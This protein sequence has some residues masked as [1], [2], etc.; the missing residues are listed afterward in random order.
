MTGVQTCA[1]PICTDNIVASGGNDRIVG[2]AGDDFL[3]GG[4]G[5]DIF[6]FASAGFGSDTIGGA[7]LDRFDFTGGDALTQ[8]LLDISGLGINAAS[9]GAN[10]ALVDM[11]TDVRVD[12]GA[13]H[14]LL[15]GVLN[16]TDISASDFILA[17]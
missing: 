8:D 16:T 2:G 1:L 7:V 13:D 10:V 9:F 17:A 15:M 14:I 4:T 6:V 11:G 3:N 5:N 12:I